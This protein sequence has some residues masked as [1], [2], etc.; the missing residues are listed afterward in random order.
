MSE[1]EKEFNNYKSKNTLE[2]VRGK[3]SSW[4]PDCLER[5]DLN[6]ELAKHFFDSQQVKID[7]LKKRIDGALGIAQIAIS[8]KGNSVAIATC[9]GLAREIE[10]ALR[11]ENEK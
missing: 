7:E 4:T 3:K 5:I 6:R 11:G 2:L 1:F 9:R 8:G 10:K